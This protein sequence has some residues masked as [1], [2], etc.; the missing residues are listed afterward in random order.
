MASVCEAQR[1]D[2]FLSRATRNQGIQKT[3][4]ED[5]SQ[6]VINLYYLYTSWLQDEIQVYRR[7]APVNPRKTVR[8]RE[9]LRVWRRRSHFSICRGTSRARPDFAPAPATYQEP[10]RGVKRNG[11]RTRDFAEDHELNRGASVPRKQRGCT[12][13]QRAYTSYRLH[14]VRPALTEQAHVVYE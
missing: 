2:C 5:A 9:D 13:Y 3:S 14:L 10:E 1:N 8:S 4:W 6:L 12:V 7:F 11:V